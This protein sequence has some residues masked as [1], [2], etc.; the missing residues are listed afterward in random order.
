LTPAEAARSMLALADR[1]ERLKPLNHDP[2]KYHVEKSEI[3]VELGELARALDPS[4]R[5]PLS[6]RRD[7]KFTPGVLVRK[8]RHVP[9]EL[10][11]A[12]RAG[13]NVGPDLRSA[14]K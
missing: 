14:F 8:G 7:S 6:S 3:V 4:A 11:G 2:E 12:R 5:S 1:V 13:R 9:V 10:R